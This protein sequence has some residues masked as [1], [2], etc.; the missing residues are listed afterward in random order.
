MKL[1]D[2]TCCPCRQCR[3][4]GGG[5]R[6]FADWGWRIRT[7]SDLNRSR[8]PVNDGATDFAGVRVVVEDANELHFG[9]LGDLALVVIDQC[10]DGLI[11][12]FGLADF[13]DENGIFFLEQG[14]FSCFLNSVVEVA[15]D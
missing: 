15:K 8:H 13:G 7:E 9:V 10:I 14:L 5:R 4:S 11:S 12:R 3:L 6:A 1:M 2:R